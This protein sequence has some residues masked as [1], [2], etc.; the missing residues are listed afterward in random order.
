MLI[1]TK[2]IRRIRV[3]VFKSMLMI[4]FTNSIPKM[5][6]NPY[7]IKPNTENVNVSTSVASTVFLSTS[8]IL[9]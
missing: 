8:P 1:V 7:C 6:G 9:V 4:E 3:L 2:V 5:L